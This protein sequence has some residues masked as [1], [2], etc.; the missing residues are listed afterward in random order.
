M[1]PNTSI[2]QRSFVK[3]IR[4]LD[5]LERQLRYFRDQAIKRKI[6]I[7]ELPEHENIASAPNT[8]DI[9]SLVDKANHLEVTMIDMTKSYE[10][11]LE[12]RS[13]MIEKRHVLL[14]CGQFFDKVWIF[15]LLLLFTRWFLFSFFLS[16]FF[17]YNSLFFLI[18]SLKVYFYFSIMIFFF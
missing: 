18:Q 6:P 13:K 10:S 17:F 4:R 15:L 5:S 7:A 16:F 1:N 9:D 11:L 8:S 2:F 12:R 3:E 14:G